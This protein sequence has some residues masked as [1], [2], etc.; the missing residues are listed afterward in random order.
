MELQE[1]APT[2]GELQ[3]HG[4]CPSG[5]ATAPGPQACL[6]RS[7]RLRILRASISAV[8]GQPHQAVPRQQ[9]LPPRAQPA[10]A[11]A[12]PR[13]GQ[14]RRG[15]GHAAPV[16]DLLTASRLIALAKPGGGA[17]PIA[18]GE[19][20]TWLTAKAALAAMGEAARAFFLPLQYGVAVPGGA[21]AVIHVARAYLDKL[22]N[23]LV[24]QTDISNAFNSIS[25]QAIATALQG[26]ELSPLLPLVK[27]TY[28]N[29]SKL[30]VDANFGSD[31]LISERGVRQGDP[32]GPLLFAAGMHTA[33]RDTAAAHPRVLCLAYADDVTFLGEATATVAAFNHFTE[34]LAHL[35]LQHNAQKCAAWSREAV[36]KDRLPHGVPFSQEGVRL[37]GSFVGPDR[38]ASQFLSGQLQEMAKPLPLLEKADPQVASLLLTRCISRRVAYLTRTTPL[39]LLPRETWSQWGTDL[40]A[41]L[42]TAC[43]LRVPTCRTE[44]ARVWAQASLPPSLGGIGITD[45]LV[46]GVFGFAASFSQAALFIAS[47]DGAPEGALAQARDHMQLPADTTTPLH[48]WL[49]ECEAALPDDAREVLEKER[50]ERTDLRLQ[51]ALALRV[52]GSTGAVGAGGTASVGAAGTGA[53]GAAGVVAADPEGTGAVSAVPGGA[54]RPRPYYVPLLQQV[55]GLQPSP[56]PPPP[57]IVHGLSSHICSYSR[58][59]LAS[60]PTSSFP[61]SPDME[62][63]S[64]RTTSPTVTRFLATAVTDPLFE[65]TTA[66]ALVTELVD[67]A[68]ACRLDYTTSLVAESVSASVCP[69]SVGCE[70]APCTDVV[71]DR[72]EEFECFAAAVPHLVSMLL[73]PEGDPDAPDIPT[74][75]SY[76][77]TIEGPYSSQWQ[78]A[79]DAEMASWK[80]T[81]T[82]IDEVPPPGA[83]IGVDFF[84]TFS[85][86]P[87]MTTLWVLLH[88]A[89]VR[90]YEL[91]S[92]DFSTAFLQSSLHEEIWLRRP[93]GFTGSFPAGTQW[94]LRRPVYGLRQAPH[95]WHNT[96][97]TTLATLCFAPSTAEPS[98]FLRTDTTLPPFYVLVYVDDLVFATANTEA[99]AHVKSEL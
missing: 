74:P 51:H 55:L 85:P 81:G 30:F 62:S 84:Q 34:K 4:G 78:A 99:L 50:L 76:A 63:E 88:V 1:P 24:L 69:P 8:H 71:E 2:C 60:P 97:R 54:A 41:A 47:L 42:L 19:C 59:P 53:G 29:P 95:E 17:R 89:A 90:D 96:L 12:A 33:L 3:G 21:E 75:R 38:G 64:L 87:K 6:R 40:L 86:T 37:L 15:T 73:A 10:R 66:S 26:P 22:P 56:G 5:S 32:L 61:D 49:S 25:R 98:L 93:P 39:S 36:V 79:M 91:H 67:F 35:G 57:Y 52:H 31:P 28:G 18:I 9:R 43:H 23:S 27:L 80:S 46:E 92:L 11:P 82:Y 58:V 20:I 44:Q 77:E 68:A 83:N 16:S 70:C 14:L 72:Q 94:S 13:A 45:P 65:S 48:T 7:P